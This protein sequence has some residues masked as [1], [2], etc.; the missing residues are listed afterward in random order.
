MSKKHLILSQHQCDLPLHLPVHHLPDHHYMSVM[1]SEMKEN[2]ELCLKYVNNHL[3]L[4]IPEHVVWHSEL[5][6][7]L[8]KKF[9]NISQWPSHSHASG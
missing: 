2:K 3:G 6:W 8:H 7:L 9:P 1:S 4:S 5:K